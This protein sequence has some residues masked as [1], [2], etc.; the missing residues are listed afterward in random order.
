MD[1]IIVSGRHG[2]SRILAGETLDKLG[3]YIPRRDVFVVTDKNLHKIYGDRFPDCPVYVMDAGEREKTLENAAR[4]CHWL[5]DKGAGRD[6]FILGIGGGMVCD[7]AGFVASVYMRGTGFGFVATSLLAQADASIG[8]KNGVNLDG[9]KNIIGTFNQPQF[10]LCDPTMLHSLPK[11]EF[12]NGLAEVVKHVLIADKKMFHVIK[13]QATAILDLDQFLI[14]K[15]IR[16]SIQTKAA[17]VNKD[18]TEESERRKLNL[19]HTWGHAVERT[20][21]IMHGQAVAIGLVFAA[22]LSEYKGKLKQDERNQ[23]VELLQSL[24]LP[25][26]SPTDPEIIFQALVKDKK[27]EGSHIHFVLMEGIG[28][29]SVEPIPVNELEHFIRHFDLK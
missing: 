25:V 27:K 5:L 8:G 15:L 1:S 12:I 10:V 21:R 9:F 2:S 22:A 4:I 24:G 7:M 13:E 17:I 14:N 29:V 20:D 6:A 28:Q 19:G 26:K 3:K 18:E 11:E 16:H 23:L